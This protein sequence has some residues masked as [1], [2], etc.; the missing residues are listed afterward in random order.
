MPIELLRILLGLLAVFFA[1]ALGRAIIRLRREKKP[2][3]KALTWALRTTVCLF[4]VMWNRGLDA[5]S[6]AFLVL[7]A[8]AFALGSHIEGRPRHIDETHLFE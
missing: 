7:C 2:Y 1:Y 5:T 8:A 4:G 3:T 6:I